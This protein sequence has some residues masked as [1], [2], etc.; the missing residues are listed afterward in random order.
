MDG[1]SGSEEASQGEWAL[2]YIARVHA[3]VRLETLTGG[4]ERNIDVTHFGCDSGNGLA[5]TS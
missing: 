5:A 3:N 2:W 1:V 4:G